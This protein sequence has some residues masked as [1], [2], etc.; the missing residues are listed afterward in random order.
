MKKI[1]KAVLKSSFVMLILFA[2]AGSSVAQEQVCRARA[3]GSNTVRAEGVTEAVEGVELSCKVVEPDAFFPE[4]PETFTVSIEL[5]T[6]IT[7][8]TDEDGEVVMGLTYTDGDGN[9]PDLGAAM[10]YTGED[11]EVLD[12]GTTIEWELTYADLNVPAAN[13]TPESVVIGGI[14]ANAS[15]VGDGEDVTA[16]VRVNGEAVHSGSLKLSDVTTGLDIT[17][18]GA[19]G[20]QCEPGSATATV[21]FVEGFASAIAATDS[22]DD[23]DTPMSLVLNFRDIPDNVTV[24]VSRMGTGMAE[25]DDGSDLAPLTL[26]VGADAMIAADAEYV[27]VDLDSNGS[28]KAVYTFDEENPATTDDMDAMNGFE[29]EG[30]DDDLAKEWN[31][32]Q[33]MFTWETGEDMAALGGGY[34]TV[35]YDPVGG[36]DIPRYAAGPTNMVVTVADCTTTLLFPYVLNQTGFD[37]GIAISNTSSESGSCAINYHGAGGPDPHESRLIAGGGQLILTLSSTVDTTGF[38]GYLVAVCDFRK[39]YGFA[40][41]LDGFGEIDSTLGLG[42]LAVRNPWNK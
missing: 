4:P 38:Q 1:H 22:T 33:V 26:D 39:A 20:L 11:K 32:V 2:V 42:Y 3:L 13:A 10:D 37:T 36:D 25:E 12:G 35:S 15:A 40:L 8:E 28:G 23:A 18:S 34:V 17:V 6:A 29:L 16:V 24:M 5:N 30:T 19:T 14:L 31:E 9:A 7:N 27:E 21:T 41:I